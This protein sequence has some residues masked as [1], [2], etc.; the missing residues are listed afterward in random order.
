MK[1]LIFGL[2]GAGKSTLAEKIV[3]RFGIPWFNADSVRKEH[4][5]WDFS[6]AGRRRQAA[7]MISYMESHKSCVVDFVCPFNDTREAF[8][9][10]FKIWM[11]TI[12]EGRFADTNHVFEVP[13]DPEC[14]HITDWDQ[15]DELM[16]ML[17]AHYAK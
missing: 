8:K 9:A 13:N 3:A 16:A 5:D 6:E 14:I 1:L 15:E 11:D 12:T 10:D 4:D 7:R 17:E 2:P